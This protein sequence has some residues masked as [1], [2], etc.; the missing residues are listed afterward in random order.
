MANSILANIEV[1]SSATSTASFATITG[2]TTGSITAPV[3]SLILLIAQITPDADG[4]DR[5]ALIRFAE[6]ATAITNGPVGCMFA[7]NTNET[8]GTTLAYF[9]EGDGTN[10]TYTVEWQTHSGTNH[11]SANTGI[12]RT[13][14]A[15]RIDNATL[16]VDISSTFGTSATSSMANMEASGSTDMAGTFTVA[17]GAMQIMLASGLMLADPGSGDKQAYLRFALGGTAEGPFGGTWVDGADDQASCSLMYAKTGQ[18]GSV[19]HSLQWEI[20]QSTPATNTTHA[21]TFQV[22]EVT[23]DFDLTSVN[24]TSIT[25]DATPAT[26]ADMDGMSG[27]IT[28]DSASSVILTL[29]CGIGE[30]TADSTSELR[31]ADGGTREGATFW[32]FLDE[33]AGNPGWML[34]RAKTGITGSHTMSMMWQQVAS[35][36]STDNARERRIQVIDFQVAAGGGGTLTADSGSYAWT[37]QTANLLHNSLIS[38]EAVSYAWSGQVANLEYHPVLSAEGASYAW[39]G[40][41]ASLLKNSLIT[42]ESVSY[43]W[44][45]QD[46][47]LTHL[48][49][50]TL[51]AES[52]SYAW[53]GQDASLLYN[54]ALSAESAA[55]NWS[56]QDAALKKQTQLTAEAVAYAWFGQD[57]TFFVDSVLQA[58][59]ASYSW[60]VQDAT[61]TSSEI[62]EVGAGAPAKKRYIMPDGKVLTDHAEALA[63]FKSQIFAEYEKVKPRS[64]R[65]TRKLK[66]QGLPPLPETI[67]EIVKM[68]PK[69]ER[70]DPTLVM[71][72][73]SVVEEDDEEEAIVAILHMI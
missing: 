55:Y 42:A 29:C 46:A 4:T 38:A 10:H 28:P 19:A 36:G 30:D 59:A 14:Q 39:S 68:L 13:L 8:S 20:G 73:Q 67:P 58:E 3:G 56:G 24:E 66:K 21:R 16:E 12:T 25:A 18:T 41:T 40:Q 60:A 61:L 53:S 49:G 22:A 33:T 31:L 64:K 6:D 44:S 32:T 69:Q 52:V 15:I 71:E 50:N 2:M 26:W 17:T 65:K 23:Q 54:A 11:V 45:G 34:A 5:S 70:F 43:T 63:E 27:A 48:A 72:A 35:V 62:G 9:V 7:D 57:A 51:I 1:S 37:G 47:T